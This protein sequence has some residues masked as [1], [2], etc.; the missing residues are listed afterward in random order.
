MSEWNEYKLN[1]LADVVM[2]QSPPSSSY[3]TDNIGLPF[4][5]GCADF[6]V[7][8]PEAK[9]FCTEPKKIAPANSILISVRA[10]VGLTN[11]SHR[12][13]VIGR[14]LAALIPKNSDLNFLFYSINHNTLKLDIVSQGSTF[15]A[16]NSDELNNFK[17]FAPLIQEQRKIARILSTIDSVIEK[18]QS[19][20]DKYKAIKQGMLHD[21]FTRGIDIKTGKLRPKYEDA[22][23]LYKPSKLG[24][25][26]NDWMIEK[27]GNEEY[28][29]LKTGGTPSTFIKEYWGGNIR[30]MSS[31]EVNKRRIFEVEGR[32]TELGMTNS[33]AVFFPIHSVVIGLAGQGKTRGT[34]AITYVETTS[35]QSIAAIIFNKILINPFYYYHLLD[36]EYEKL[37]SVSA[38][39][40]RAG[41]SL[42]ILG[43]YKV[44]KPNFAEQNEIAKR[45][46]TIDCK[47]ITEHNYLNKLQMLKSGLMS[48]LLSGKKPVKVNDEDLLK[49]A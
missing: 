19:A 41:L 46:E 26:P 17:L 28:F 13:F 22:P 2:G 8:Y 44:I 16:I 5:Q 40:G 42:N 9:F 31:G 6:G 30:W 27:F 37:R 7:V 3:N 4:L 1:E 25:I 18:T 14:G 43:E 48:D 38:G 33:N 45:L 32:I 11:L 23:E 39:A 29:N 10:P 15:S 24:W 21:L 35:N 12:T 20:I 36:F 34:V 47:I 49:T